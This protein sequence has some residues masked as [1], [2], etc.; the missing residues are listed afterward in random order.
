MKPFPYG[1]FPFVRLL[2][3]LLLGEIIS[4]LIPP[5]IAYLV[6]FVIVTFLAVYY[7]HF[8]LEWKYSI[9]W[10]TG[11]LINLTLLL[12][13]WSNSYSSKATSVVFDEVKPYSGH[14]LEVLKNSESKQ[15]LKIQVTELKEEQTAFFY[16]IVY[17]TKDSSHEALLPGDNIL[18]KCSLQ[19]VLSDSNP[20][21]FKYA[22]YL[23]SRHVIG[24]FFLNQSKI[25]KL[26]STFS[27]EKYFYSIRLWSQE[28]LTAVKF[29]AKVR[30]ILVA[31]LLG[32]K[33]NLDNDVKLDFSGSG[34][35]HIIS[36][37]GMHVGIIY[38]L[39]LFV[40]GG[41][42]SK[43]F[44]NFK[45]IITLICLWFYASLTGMTPSVF[46]ATIMFSILIVSKRLNHAEYNLYHSLSIAAF[47]ILLINPIAFINIGFW[48]S[49]LAVISIVYFYPK[50]NSL[51]YFNKPWN[52]FLWSL[53]SLSISAQIGTA[54]LV[55]FTFG[56]FPIWFFISNLIIVPLVPFIFI[57]GL[58]VI[59]FPLDSVVNLFIW[60]SLN[61]VVMLVVDIAEWINRFHFSKF[62][63]LQ[64]S[65]IEVFILYLAIIFVIIYRNKKTFINYLGVLVTFLLFITINT[66][67]CYNILSKESIVIHEIN[68]CS[69]ISVI[70]KSNDIYFLDRGVDKVHVERSVMPLWRTSNRS[71]INKQEI[72][73]QKI[74]P[75]CNNNLFGVIINGDM[76]LDY[77][78]S[79]KDK[80]NIVIVTRANTHKGIINILKYF[81]GHKVVFDSSFSKNEF[82]QLIDSYSITC[83]RVCCVSV[84]GAIKID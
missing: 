58:M 61:D 46:R 66:I 71:E 81:D 83:G 78:N 29:D 60:S 19:H 76:N 70:S 53:F 55:I 17:F 10:I 35:M 38:L 13:G 77:L 21:T 12:G 2:I 74:L 26:K 5:S 80:I 48:L 69:M 54:P 65:I 41:L 3:P 8:K 28:K 56:Y 4:L 39:L 30:G 7:L 50:I 72:L 24:Q 18:F 22:D 42:K 40:L 84:D 62:A 36:I 27:I 67:Y 75:V 79:I 68:G 73:N 11:L 59:L 49:F 57:G 63:G 34:L 23:E 64:L 25:V 37:S 31:L 16:A 47:V 32:N 82:T 52:R 51:V 1:A 15:T 20:Y 14:V 9:R 44:G 6:G 33:T 43:K 45:L